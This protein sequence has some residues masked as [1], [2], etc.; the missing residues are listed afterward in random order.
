MVAVAPWLPATLLACYRADYVMFANESL[1][2]RYFACERIQHGERGTV[3]LPQGQLLGVVQHGILFA[4]ERFVIA[5]NNQIS[6]SGRLM[7]LD[8]ISL[9]PGPA[10]F[11]Q[12]TATVSAT[13]FLVPAAQGL[14]NGA[15]TAGPA[16]AAGTPVAG[17]AS[18]VPSAPAAIASPVK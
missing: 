7:T 3:W 4:L 6:V 16:G 18:P 2:Y 9:G 8:G 12:I 5:K 10:G 17:S 14:M 13:T 1:A 11:P 15:T